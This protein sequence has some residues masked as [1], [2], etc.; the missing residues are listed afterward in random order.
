MANL[1]KKRI[2]DLRL[3]NL[4]SGD[5]LTRYQACNIGWQ[6]LQRIGLEC[7]DLPAENPRNRFVSLR[8]MTIEVSGWTGSSR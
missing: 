3:A 2:I 1:T 6:A 4:K 5:V 7:I 8:P